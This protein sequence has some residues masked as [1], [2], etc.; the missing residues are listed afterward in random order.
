MKKGYSITIEGL[1][2]KVNYKRK[3][4][5]ILT[6]INLKIDEG[7][8]VAIV[9]CSGAGKTTLMKVLSNYTNFTS[10][11][12]Y[13]NGID[14]KKSEKRLKGKIGYV[15]QTEILDGTLTLCK[16]LFYSLKLRVRNISND[17]AN[18]TITNILKMVEL[19]S[20]KDTL[21][22]NLSGGER[23]R[24][25]LATEMLSDP[26]LFLLDEPTSGLDANIEKKLMK[27][28]REIANNGKTIVIT[29][30]T[31]SNLQLCDKIIFMGSNG[32]ICYYG[33]YDEIFNYFNVE[34][35][36]DIYDILKNDTD[37]WHMKYRSTVSNNRNKNNTLDTTVDKFKNVGFLS[38][39][40]TLIQ[41]FK[42]S[43]FNNKFMML[44]LLGQPIMMAILM[45][46]ATKRSSLMDPL[47]AGMVGGAAISMAAMWLGLFNTIQE[48]AKEKDILMKEYT[49]GLKLSSY[50]V[51][52]MIVFSILCFYQAIACVTILYFYLDP[53]PEKILIIRPLLDLI[54]HFFL[55]S[56]STSMI[57]I[58][59]S[60]I[61]KNVKTTLI[62]APLYMMIQM[63]FSGMFLPYISLTRFISY[64]VIGRWS[65]EGF[66]TI[67]NLNSFGVVS[68]E[69]GFFD[70]TQNH[71]FNIWL[72]L[73]IFI[74]SFL[75][76]SIGT[77]KHK[78]KTCS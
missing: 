68:M 13:I 25:S 73:A 54:L 20:V 6:D 14:I 30:H 31:V 53:R 62:V 47:S 78:L 51:S 56:F 18:Q 5:E 24:A 76:L 11:N 26:N 9:G 49:S 71:I 63:L 27:K 74:F 7:S 21:I 61:V 36:V 50:I 48:I 43:L 66:G 28:L 75:I 41:R 40:K 2:K 59:V 4:K 23:K 60:S 77:I 52:K 35:F 42:T 69:K 64:F 29:A 57:G 10:G 46:S 15:P 65:Y 8:F 39:T 44:L 19:E 58:F 70:F 3:E 32:K 33:S 38:Q 37:T 22:K 45:C 34:E 67:N 17:Q 55:V 1:C 16:S 12:V 72:I